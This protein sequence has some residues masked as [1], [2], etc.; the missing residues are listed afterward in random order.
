M[1][2]IKMLVTVSMLTLIVIGCGSTQKVVQPEVVTPAMPAVPEWYTTLPDNPDTLYAA[3]EA[4]SKSMQLAIDKAANNA[5]A[6]IGRQI[7]LKMENMQK[8]FDEEVGFGEDSELLS[9]YTNVTK[10]VV[11]VSISGSKILKQQPAR[12]DKIWQA[13]VLVTYPLANMNASLVDAV[14][15]EN[16]LYQRFQASKAFK[17][18]EQ[19]MEAYK[20]EQ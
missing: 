16:L 11:S 8:Q 12:L 2:T 13:Y 10:A 7:E 9:Q 5:R 18:L 1:R 6:E 3:R 4:T 19:E 15:K 17:E 14:K 20:A